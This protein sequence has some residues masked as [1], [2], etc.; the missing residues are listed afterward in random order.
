MISCLV[1]QLVPAVGPR[2]CCYA[3]LIISNRHAE[4]IEGSKSLCAKIS[5][6]SMIPCTSFRRRPESSVIYGSTGG[7]HLGSGFRRSDEYIDTGPIDAFDRG[8]K[9]PGHIVLTPLPMV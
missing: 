2:T 8:S 5:G 9:V 4:R 7:R 3:E 1:W 6:H